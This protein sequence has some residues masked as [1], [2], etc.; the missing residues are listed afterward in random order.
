MPSLP[1]RQ[2]SCSR[3]R[4]ACMSAH[5]PAHR[6][7][8]HVS[9]WAMTR[10]SRDGFFFTV[11][12]PL[13]LHARCRSRC[14]TQLRDGAGVPNPMVSSGTPACTLQQHEYTAFHADMML[15][16]RSATWHLSLCV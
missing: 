9:I 3:Y 8:S 5:K 11:P 15:P 16:R 14:W 6:P 2:R 12:R 4:F 1:E 10:S 13:L 7:H